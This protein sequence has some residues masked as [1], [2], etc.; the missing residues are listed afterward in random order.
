MLPKASGAATLSKSDVWELVRLRSMMSAP[1]ST[2]V[3][4]KLSVPIL[5]PG[6]I[7]PSL[8][9]T[10]L[11]AGF[12]RP[13]PPVIN[14]VS[15][16]SCDVTGQPLSHRRMV[17]SFYLLHRADDACTRALGSAQGGAR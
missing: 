4:P 1:F 8:V 17:I 15:G 13:Y 9:T 5:M 14:P 6:L 11:I 16:V 12:P 3:L 7:V 2:G 10:P